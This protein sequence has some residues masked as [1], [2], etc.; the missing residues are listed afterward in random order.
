MDIRQTICTTYVVNGG[1][2]EE[3]DADDVKGKD[4]SEENEHDCGAGGTE[5]E[6]ERESERGTKG[7][8]VTPLSSLY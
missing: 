3:D 6:R 1:H 8:L 2:Q 4:G 5:R 7:K